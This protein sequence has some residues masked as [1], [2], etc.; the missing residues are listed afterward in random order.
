MARVFAMC[1]LA[2][3]VLSYPRV[4]ASEGE[5]GSPTPPPPP[6]GIL[7]PQNFPRPSILFAFRFLNPR[8]IDSMARDLNLSDAQKAQVTQLINKLEETSKPKIQAQHKA[9]EEFAIALADQSKTESELKAAAD[10]VF[11]AESDLVTEN[12]KTLNAIRALLTQEQSTAFK[13]FLEQRTMPYRTSITLTPAG[14]PASPSTE[15]T[16]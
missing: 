15:V 6:P 2:I 13:K 9:V 5:A 8:S 7:G 12:I 16:K 1:V 10:K 4:L 11:K 14:P 3:S